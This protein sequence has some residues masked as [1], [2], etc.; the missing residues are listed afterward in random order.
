MARRYGLGTG[1]PEIAPHQKEED[2]RLMNPVYQAISGLAKACSD[3]IGLTSI[4]KADIQNANT[5]IEFTGNF[6]KRMNFIAGA[7]VEP[8]RLIWLDGTAGESKMWHADAT[9]GINRVAYGICVESTTVQ[10]GERGRVILFS[11]LLSGISGVTPGTIYW[12][13]A[14]GQFSAAMPGAPGWTQQKV[15]LGITSNSIM[16]NINL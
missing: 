14:N 7:A 15:G 9:S 13:G 1:L 10:P 6:G 12:L 4:D 11:G 16:V 5:F 8:A 2:F 3:A